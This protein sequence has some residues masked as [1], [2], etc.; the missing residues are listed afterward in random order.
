[1]PIDNGRVFILGCQSASFA[2][3]TFSGTTLELDSCDATVSG[4]TFNRGITIGRTQQAT[5]SSIA[6]SNPDGVALAVTGAAVTVNNGTITNAA[7]GIDSDSGSR[8][9]Y[10]GSITSLTDDRWVKACNWSKDSDCG[11]DA[12]YVDW[13]GAGPVP[14]GGASRVCGQVLVDPWVGMNGDNDVFRSPNCDGSVY[15]P[16]QQLGTASSYANQRLA[17]V[18]ATCDPDDPVTRDACEVYERFQQCYG[19]AIDLAK[20]GSTF[21]I[22]ETPD[23]VASGLAGVLSDALAS[24]PDPF[25]ALDGQLFQRLTGLL[26]VVNIAS[27]LIN[28][29]YTCAP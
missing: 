2:D 3:N 22:P 12:S 15:R 1:L 28:A 21:P 5:L 23:D 7:T 27:S 25:V 6:I 17:E 26:Q 18:Y 29:Y 10:R 20:A 16:D 9:A 8:V 11:V 14:A 19:A 4:G 24:S 13:G